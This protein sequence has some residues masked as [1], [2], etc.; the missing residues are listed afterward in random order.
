METPLHGATAI[1]EMLLQ[2]WGGRLRVFPAVAKS[3]PNVQFARL[4]GEGGFLVSGKRENGVCQ[5]VLVKAEHGRTVEI[6]PQIEWAMW[7]T[8]KGTASVEAV[9]N[10]VYR[11]EMQPESTVLFWPKGNPQPVPTVAPVKRG[12]PFRVR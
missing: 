12:K 10:G 2:S 1:Q 6:E 7:T 5:W 8:S 11:L 4:R 9:E 3:W